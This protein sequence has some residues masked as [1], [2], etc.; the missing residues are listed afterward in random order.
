MLSRRILTAAQLRLQARNIDNVPVLSKPAACDTPDVDRVETDPLA[1]WFKTEE[2]A[3]MSASPDVARDDLVTSEDAIFNRQM[4]IGKYAAQ[5]LYTAMLD[6]RIG[7]NL[8]PR[9]DA[10]LAHRQ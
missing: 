1:R 10:I 2:C 4:D 9:A 3:A 7:K 5:I 6:I 8:A